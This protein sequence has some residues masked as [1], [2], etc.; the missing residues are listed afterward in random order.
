MIRTLS[1][2]LGLSGLSLP[3]HI[4]SELHAGIW[5]PVQ[6]D[7]LTLH[8]Q[9]EKEDC[10]SFHPGPRIHPNLITVAGATSCDHQIKFKSLN[11]LLTITLR[12]IRALR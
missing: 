6:R 2:L 3:P 7:L 4:D 5:Q 8:T 12:P 1:E 9:G 10:A 11:Q